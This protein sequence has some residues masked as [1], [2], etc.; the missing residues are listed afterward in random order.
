MFFDNGNFVFHFSNTATNST[1]NTI[2]KRFKNKSALEAIC[3]YFNPNTL[4]THF[5]QQD[6]VKYIPGAA[7]VSSNSTTFSTMWS[8]F[9]SGHF[10]GTAT[11]LLPILNNKLHSSVAITNVLSRVLSR[12]E[13]ESFEMLEIKVV[14]AQD[15]SNT[16]LVQALLAENN[17]EYHYEDTDFGVKRF[18]LWKSFLFSC[19]SLIT[20]FQLPQWCVHR[21]SAA[22][23]QHSSQAQDTLRTCAGHQSRCSAVSQEFERQSDECSL[24]W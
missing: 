4:F 24:C 5:S 15:L 13:K 17:S 23:Q 14:S 10:I 11:L 18:D 12:L 6:C 20:H 7:A 3:T 21:H 16:K 2:I 9:P 1:N 22:S 8:L 19:I